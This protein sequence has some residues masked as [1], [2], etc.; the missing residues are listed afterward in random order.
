MATTKKDPEVE[1][2]GKL[3]E[4][5]D[6]LDD[7]D[8]QARTIRWAAER[9]GVTLASNAPRSVGGGGNGGGG[10]DPADYKDVGELVAAAA[11]PTPEDRALVV[12][13]WLQEVREGKQPTFTGQQVNTELKHLGHGTDDIT[14]LIGK[15]VATSPQQVLQTRKS[16]T[17]RQA[18]K[19][20]KVTKAGARR[21]QELLDAAS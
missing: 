7:P 3:A 18:R 8:Q 20:Y 4:A 2:M 10:S 5:L 9:Y 17:T 13:Y 21:V 16:G 19:T 12:A 6:A 15:L 1:A 11:P 14:D